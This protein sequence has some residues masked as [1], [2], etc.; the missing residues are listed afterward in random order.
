MSFNVLTIAEIFKLSELEKA[1]EEDDKIPVCGYNFCIMHSSPGS[2]N[3]NLSTLET[4]KVQ[5][6][7]PDHQPFPACILLQWA[8]IF[9]S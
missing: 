6:L 4:M 7:L 2:S 1:E 9:S 5:S 3:N 8:Y